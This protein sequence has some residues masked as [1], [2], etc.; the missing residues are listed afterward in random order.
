MNAG[1][2]RSVASALCG[3]LGVLLLFA[4]TLLGYATRSVFD[5][6]G[7]SER[8]AASLAQPEV[9]EFAA[10]RIA[11]AVIQASPDLMGVRPVLIGLTRGVVASA[12]FRAGVRRGARAV[13]HSIM[14][15][16]SAKLVLNV[17]DL[18]SILQSAAAL[19]P[20][21][22]KR[23]PPG[24]SSTLG[25]LESVPG[26]AITA[27][28]I[29]LGH[30]MR[31]LTLALLVL[32]LVL[33]AVCVWLASEKRRALVRLGVTLIGL[34]LLLAIVSRFGGDV[35]AMMARHRDSGP[36]LAGLA[37]VF[38]RGLMTWALVLGFVGLVLAAASASL[39]E[40]VPISAWLERSWWWVTHPHERMLMR[41]V[42]GIAAA[43]AGAALLFWPLP[44]I[45]VAAWCTGLVVA[46]VGLRESF[47]AALHMLP[48]LE[49]R[50]ERERA[51]RRGAPGAGAI[52]LV[53][54]IAVALA[55][56]AWWLLRPEA[57]QEPDQTHA[58][59]ACNGS[60][61]LC[62]RR[63]DQVVFPTT[64]NSMGGAD[65]PTW[66]FPNQTAGIRKQLEDGVRGFLIDVHNG[67]PVG[68]KVKTILADEGAAMAKYE[69]AL[70]E[71]GMAAVLRIRDRLA[72]QE[73]GPRDLYMC[74]GFCEL[75]A[76]KL[77][78]VL[79]EV[80]EFLVE[81]PG[82]VLI[83][84]VQDEGVAPADVERCF[85]ESGL[86]DFVYKGSARPPWPTLR[87]MI[88]TD[89]RVVVMAENDT[90]GVA[91]YHPAFEVMQETPYT[92]HTPEEF[93]NAPNRGGT[94]GSLLLMN[95]WIESTPMPKPSNA[96][97][98]NARG[99]LL[100]RIEACERERHHMVNLVA[101]DFY[102]VG[103][104]IPVVREL[105]ERPLPAKR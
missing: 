100:K 66:M 10:E 49:R 59:M 88:A 21:L 83:F 87:E 55:A 32:G 101:V 35:L 31:T 27:R 28:L 86:I 89:Q 79:K 8:V 16:G 54:A 47:V 42:R 41:L 84:V 78:P 7:F 65:D 58:I 92:F 23:I 26:G 2:Y 63:L 46:F 62:D 82:E 33:C 25:D 52:A 95:H 11:D 74:H 99:V 44:A 34:A 39:L 97:I 73:G 12:P 43:A 24:L 3:G 48:D 37:G 38:L 60:P 67:E 72:G 36:L 80:R 15:G 57:P 70:G 69:K 77:T 22:A 20:A 85:R 71:E 61:A 104:L 14:S 18:S 53:S 102:G 4:S 81:N 64:H 94:A 5:E 29:R 30:R 98:V 51:T 9:A 93:S 13:H 50:A 17:Q 75:G 56:G 68:D 40:R 19:H 1:R 76:L 45:V 105:N 96:E 103:D 6:R 90:T 91:W